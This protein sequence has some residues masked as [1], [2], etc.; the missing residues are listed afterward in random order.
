MACAL[1]VSELRLSALNRTM[2]DL[3]P[4]TTFQRFPFC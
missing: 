2:E 3:R 4:T 1:N